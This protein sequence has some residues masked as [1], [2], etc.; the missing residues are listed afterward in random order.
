MFVFRQSN[1]ISLVYRIT[2]GL[3]FAVTSISVLE[4]I[5]SVQLDTHTS[6]GV[7][8]TCLDMVNG[9]LFFSPQSDSTIIHFKSPL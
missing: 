1:P 9:V 3:E 6:S 4:D 7:L 5:S 2:S 8:F